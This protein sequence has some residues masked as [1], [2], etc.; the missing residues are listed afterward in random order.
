MRPLVVLLPTIAF[1]VLAGSPFLQM[2]LAG[3]GVDM[4][5]SRLEA[6]QGYDRLVADFPGQDQTTFTV[7]VDYPDGSPLTTQ[8]IADQYH[9]ERRIAAIPGVL[10]TSSLYDLDPNLDTFVD[11]ASR[12][13]TAPTAA[14]TR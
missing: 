2:R 7:V 5:P 1:L 10:R 4:L 6:R 14:A 12:Y 9:L 3:G 8:R 13:L 11:W